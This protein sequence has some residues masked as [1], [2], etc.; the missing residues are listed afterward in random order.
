MSFF[1][2]A[3]LMTL[4]TFVLQ[5][6]SST[7]CDLLATVS[8]ATGRD[9]AAGEEEE[10]EEETDGAEEAEAAPSSAMLVCC[11]LRTMP[12]ADDGFIVSTRGIGAL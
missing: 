12:A 7:F 5:G 9:G 10:G 11:M 3:V 6:E 1:A 2:V 4:L 8:A